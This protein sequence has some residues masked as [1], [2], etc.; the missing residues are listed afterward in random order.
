M[1]Q[2]EY[3][4]QIDGSK[5][6]PHQLVDVRVKAHA[7]GGEYHFIG[8]VISFATPEGTIMVRRIPGQAHTMQEYP[9]ADLTK[10]ENRN[11]R[12]V[13]Y[14]A[15]KG[16]GSFPTD[17]LRYDRCVPVNF[18][19]V[20]AFSGDKAVIDTT[21]DWQDGACI[22]ARVSE[23]MVPDW[24][25]ARWSSFMWGCRNFRTDKLTGTR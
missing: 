4:Q 16:M 18:H 12:Y 21:A 6:K 5:L 24:T 23:T 11:Y 13:H 17:Q 8:E 3:R 14:A 1:L 20:K 22:V 15:V 2:D 19:L 10:V 7:E 9:L 25:I